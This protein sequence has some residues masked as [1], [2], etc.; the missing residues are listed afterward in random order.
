LIGLWFGLEL[1]L[2]RFAFLMPTAFTLVMVL[3]LMT[4]VSP[5]GMTHCKAQTCGGNERD[6]H[7]QDPF[8]SSIHVDS[9]NSLEVP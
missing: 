4:V 7:A 3:T 2:A 9:I 6:C 1:F 5:I 8:G